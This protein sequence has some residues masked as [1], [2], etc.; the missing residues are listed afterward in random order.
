MEKETRMP[1]QRKK[2][3]KAGIFTLNP[4]TFCIT[5]ATDG[6][7]GM[8]GYAP[9]ELASFAL[10][11]IWPN[12][13][14]RERFARSIGGQNAVTD[15]SADLIRRDG[16]LLPVTIAAASFPDTDITCIVSSRRPDTQESRKPEEHL[17]VFDSLVDAV[18]ILDWDGTALFA[19]SAAATLV[20]VPSPA[21]LFGRN[22]LQFVHPDYAEAVASD[23][24]NVRSGR[25][26]YLAHYLVRDL[27]GN[28]KWVEGLGTKVLFKG[29]EADI[30]ALRDITGRKSVEGEL[31]R[32]NQQFRDLYRLAR[33]MCDNVPDLI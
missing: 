32:T 27:H 22:P 30:V 16:E 31:A 9:E 25:D 14:E 33:M 29:R 12:K 26:G 19:N 18:L 3:I 20:G 5:R 11:E 8:L 10:S 28:E 2:S 24:K 13:V 15:I 6:I 17:Q 21:D 4:H 23:P 7:S 1:E